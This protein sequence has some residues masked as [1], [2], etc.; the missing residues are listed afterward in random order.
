MP[1]QKRSSKWW[2]KI[3]K[4]Q[5]FIFY[6]KGVVIIF[7]IIVFRQKSGLCQRKRWLLLKTL[8]MSGAQ[9][10]LKTNKGCQKRLLIFCKIRIQK[11]QKQNTFIFQRFESDDEESE[12]EEKILD[13]HE[14]PEPLSAFIHST[15]SLS[16]NIFQLRLRLYM[17][18]GKCSFFSML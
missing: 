7:V 8:F 14:K 13:K 3:I 4:S 2:T 16:P 9:L 18:S 1:S 17:L 12:E 5:R 11:T 15:R 10:P 6:I